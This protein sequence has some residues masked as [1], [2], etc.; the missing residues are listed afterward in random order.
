MPRVG[1]RGPAK[2][3]LTRAT[4]D[5]ALEW[6]Y[7]PVSDQWVVRRWWRPLHVRPAR[8]HLR[9]AQQ[10]LRPPRGGALDSTV[11]P[12]VIA[13]LC[14]APLFVLLATRARNLSVASAEEL[15]V[16]YG[17]GV[18]TATSL[19]MFLAF[20]CYRDKSQGVELPAAPPL[21][22]CMLAVKDDAE[23]IVRC[24]SSIL[25]SDYPAF[26][27]IVVDDGSTDGTV[28]LLEELVQRRPFTLLLSERNMGKKRALVRAASVARGEIFM[29][30][31]SDCVISPFAVTQAVKALLSDDDIG[32]VSGHARAL[33]GDRTILTRIQDTWYDGQFA[34][35]KAAESVFGTVTCVSGPMAVFRRAA[36]YNYLP[37][38]AEDRF[39]GKPF[40]FATDR[41]LTA[42]VLGQE[43]VGKKLKRAH[44][45]SPF[46]TQEIHP[47]RRWR[48]EYVASARALTNV[49]ETPRKMLKQQAR[50]K[51]SFIRN[52]FFTGGFLWRRGLIPAFLFYG[53]VLWVVVA[54]FMAFRHLVWA[55]LN[56][57]LIL[58]AVYLCGVLLKGSLWALAYKIQNPGSAR[59]L[60][61]P[62]MSLLS[63]LC[64]S[65][66][67]P[68]SALTLR[69]SVWARG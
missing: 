45:Q 21:V 3:S 23:V 69:K 44:A 42:Y 65:W 1:S 57:G 15:L 35:A 52:L 19:V 56:G 68:Y 10:H 18:L 53:H 43:R 17:V 8:Q 25:D 29:F 34:V 41:Q 66:V 38:W 24:V 39:L 50:W 62:A 27:L 28:E 7:Q 61:R 36:I 58:T 4:G 60:Y 22:S 49:P 31:D 51:K 40:L 6:L 37:A 26:E 47:P 67:L 11:R 64:L 48:V 59:W 16:L 33:N 5:P 12:R 30:T 46:V 63:A 32:G 20:A 2:P 54:P 14:L 55:P 9:R 13:T